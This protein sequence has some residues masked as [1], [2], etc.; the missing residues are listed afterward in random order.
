MQ[1]ICSRQMPMVSWR[2]LP[3]NQINVMK[4]ENTFIAP[5][6]IS[7]RD[8]VKKLALLLESRPKLP[9]NSTGE[10][11]LLLTRFHDLQLRLGGGLE[12]FELEIDKMLNEL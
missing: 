12:M 1:A 6:V 4:A 9:A 3:N 11:Q 7:L 2:L 8:G 10:Q 5:S